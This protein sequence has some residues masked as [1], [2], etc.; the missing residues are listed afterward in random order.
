[1]T[2][3]AL[4]K[5]GTLVRSLE[6]TE[7]HLRGSDEIV[8]RLRAIKVTLGE[9]PKSEPWL[10]AWLDREHVK[11]AM[12]AAAAKTNYRKWFGT[13][14]PAAQAARD[15]AIHRFNEWRD[16]LLEHISTYRTSEQTEAVVRPWQQRAQAFFDDPTSPGT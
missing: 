8:D 16:E 14:N 7:D 15:S 13:D 5:I 9:L 6:L 10:R 11:A 4:D 12:L 3:Q 2:D 1:M